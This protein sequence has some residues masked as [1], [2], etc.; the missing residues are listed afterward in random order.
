MQSTATYDTFQ[1]QCSGVIQ[2]WACS[3]LVYALFP[4][5]AG[6]EGYVAFLSGRFGLAV[7][8]WVVS[9]TGYF[10]LAVS[11]SE[12]FGRGISVHKELIIYVHPNDYIGK[13]KNTLTG[14]IPSGDSN[15][16][17]GW[18]MASRLTVGSW[19]MFVVF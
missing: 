17:P 11:V 4:A 10:G 16:W 9:V 7:S 2:W 5:E 3:S 1:I 13:W 14:V 12:H 15:G 18:A 8:V 6:C 19:I